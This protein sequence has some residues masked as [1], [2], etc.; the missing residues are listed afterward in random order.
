M[1]TARARAAGG[2]AALVALVALG[3]CSPASDAP[4]L[5]YWSMWEEDEP[6]AAILRDALDDFERETGT[7][8]EVAWQGRTVATKVAPTIRAGGSPDLFD[9][10]SATVYAT[11]HDEFVDLADVYE[12]EVPGEQLTVAES[13]VG[14]Y[15]DQVVAPGGDGVFLV[16]YEVFA[17]TLF[18]DGAALPQLAERPPQTF[19]EF[20]A[21]LDDLKAA[22]R[23]PLAVDG[24]IGV[25]QAMWAAYG[26]QS[27]LGQEAF[28]ALLADETGERWTSDPAVA[29]ALDDL[30]RLGAGD[31]W[32]DGSWGSRF[33]AMQEKWAR[34]ASDVILNGTWLPS[35]VELSASAGREWRQL[36]WP[37][38]S[39][40]PEHPTVLAGTIG[41]AVPSS[42]E[43]PDAAMRF[44]A[45]FLRHEYQQAIATDTDNLVPRTD[46]A[47]P[48]VLADVAA[49]LADPASDVQGVFGTFA[50]SNPTYL[51][52]VFS[53]LSRRL[54]TGELDGP[55]FA[56][57]LA[58]AQAA[59]WSARPVDGP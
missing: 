16:P 58:A 45:W 9:Q 12:S 2:V 30:A 7:R 51:D 10:N 6:Q 33:P 22:G 24:D 26:L 21:V 41:F 11:L 53:P 8:V 18:Y 49:T 1:R 35:E 34:G 36:A 55:A 52:E 59:Y 13:G 20:V 57:A 56:S 40:G 4:A 27:A 5:T 47:P 39:A 23:R 25:Y 14:R 29:A 43:H 19:D 28:D 31:Y 17:Y 46:V 48:R 15:R 32:L 38:G 37:S 42:A 3:G 50:M 54:L 44:I